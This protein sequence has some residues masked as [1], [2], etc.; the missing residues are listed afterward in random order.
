MHNT[1]PRTGSTGQERYARRCT[2]DNDEL[3]AALWPL[4]PQTRLKR[5]VFTMSVATMRLVEG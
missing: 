2:T 3:G 4:P 5:A 1:L